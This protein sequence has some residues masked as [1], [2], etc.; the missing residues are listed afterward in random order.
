MPFVGCWLDYSLRV[1]TKE[2]CVCV[3]NPSQS[4]PIN[5]FYNSNKF[6]LLFFKKNCLLVQISNIIPNIVL[7]IE[8]N[9]VHHCTSIYNFT[10]VPTILKYFPIFP[11]LLYPKQCQ[12]IWAMATYD[13]GGVETHSMTQ[14]LRVPKFV[15]T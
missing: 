15:H 11:I 13:R 4:P 10:Y 12:H 2:V 8:V 6:C 1:L 3:C 14:C 7:S 5:L 9:S